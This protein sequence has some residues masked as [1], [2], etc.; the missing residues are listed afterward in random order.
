MNTITTRQR[1][2]LDA[3]FTEVIDGKYGFALL[4][5]KNNIEPKKKIEQ[6]KKIEPIEYVVETGETLY[7]IYANK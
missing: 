4:N 6:K 2:Y 1:L 3:M 5:T 7:K